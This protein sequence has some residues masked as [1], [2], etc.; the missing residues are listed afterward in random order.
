MW[1]VKMSLVEAWRTRGAWESRAGQFVRWLVY[2]VCLFAGLYAAVL[3]G[4]K[5]GIVVTVGALAFFGWWSSAFV[6]GRG[7]MNCLLILLLIAINLSCLA[8]YVEVLLRHKAA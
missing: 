8:A 1:H 6:G 3:F 2:F 5:A 4:P 7:E